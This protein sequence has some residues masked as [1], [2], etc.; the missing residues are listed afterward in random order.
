MVDMIQRIHVSEFAFYPELKDMPKL[1][2]MPPTGL[3]NVTAH[4]STWSATKYLV[5]TDK[6][7]DGR[8]LTTWFDKAGNLTGRE[9]TKDG[10]AAMGVHIRECEAIDKGER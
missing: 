7:D 8:Y 6:L 10:K 2:N 5:T 9:Y 1:P 4:V 3:G